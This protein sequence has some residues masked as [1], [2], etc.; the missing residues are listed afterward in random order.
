MVA[1]REGTVDGA[2][3]VIATD[4][5]G[6]EYALLSMYS[7]S[8]SYKHYVKNM[9]EGG[10]TTMSHWT[11]ITGDVNS[12]TIPMLNVYEAH[13]DVAVNPFIY[14][15]QDQGFDIGMFVNP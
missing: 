3:A 13:Q 2:P 10:G 4:D 11:E 1:V 7:S 8:A 15:L 5:D 14:W 12:L 9:G 6:K